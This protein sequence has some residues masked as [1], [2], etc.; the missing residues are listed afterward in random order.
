MAL[1]P[2]REPPHISAEGCKPPQKAG[3]SGRPNTAQ[4]L[5]AVS[6]AQ[7]I[8]AGLPWGMPGK[9]EVMEG[10]MQQAPQWG[11]QFMVFSLCLRRSV[12]YT[13]YCR[14]LLRHGKWR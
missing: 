8:P 3:R 14:G 1:A 10:A 6:C 5:A 12:F 4:A 2:S 9:G 7:R 11:R 13:G